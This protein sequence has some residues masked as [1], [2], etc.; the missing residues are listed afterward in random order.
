MCLIEETHPLDRLYDMD[1]IDPDGNTLSRSRYRKC[2]LCNC[3]A[4]EC[5]RSRKHSVDEMFAAVMHMIR[6][7]QTTTTP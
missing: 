2:L 3:Q 4:Q 5:A 6:E 1:V 7:W